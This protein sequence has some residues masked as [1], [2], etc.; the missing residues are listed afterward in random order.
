MDFNGSVDALAL[1]KIEWYVSTLYCQSLRK[2][3]RHKHNIC[4]SDTVGSS[5]LGIVGL[6]EMTE[7]TLSI[8]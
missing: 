3:K 7:Q 2:Q 4:I 5:G 6:L 1:A 8:L